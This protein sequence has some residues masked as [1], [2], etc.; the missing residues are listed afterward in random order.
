MDIG[1]KL[2]SIGYIANLGPEIPSRSVL[3]TKNPRGKT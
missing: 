3:G 1:H 2:T